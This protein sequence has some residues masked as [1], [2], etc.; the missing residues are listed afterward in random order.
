[1]LQ[2]LGS[3][4]KEANVVGLG[5]ACLVIGIILWITVMPAV[6]WLLMGIG[7]LLILVGLLIGA[8][9]SL[10]RAADRRTY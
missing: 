3:H 6:G 10:G 5:I 2:S 9:W 4:R 1:V 8:V 7:V